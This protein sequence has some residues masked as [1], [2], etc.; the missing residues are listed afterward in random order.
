MSQVRTLY[1]TDLSNNVIVPNTGSI[2]DIQYA[3]YDT[4]T[5][6]YYGYAGSETE[7]IGTQSNVHPMTLALNNVS[8]PDNYV[9]CEWMFSGEE[10]STSDFGCRIL[11]NGSFITN[12]FGTGSATNYSLHWQLFANW[13]FDGNNSST[14]HSVRILYVGRAA[15]IGR[16]EYQVWFGSGGAGV[17]NIYYINRTVSSSGADSNEVG[18][19]TGVIYELSGPMLEGATA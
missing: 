15:A 17:N 16:V 3:R 12:E 2:L 1:V 7:S 10:N 11:R 8:S 4:R 13:G 14:P 18:V 6:M 5:T 19:T 9:I